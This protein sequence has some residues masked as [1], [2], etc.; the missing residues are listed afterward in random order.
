MEIIDMVTDSKD[1]RPEIQRY[2]FANGYPAQH[3]AEV[4]CKCNSREFKVL[5]DDNQGAAVRICVGCNHQHPIGDSAEYLDNAKLDECSCPCGNE[6]F[7]MMVGVSLYDQSNDVRWIYLGLCCPMCGLIAVYGDWK[8][9]F[10]GYSELL[11][12]V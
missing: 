10:S 3:F 11:A 6:S 1:I 5:I 12:R 4:I 2:S 9:E 8:L 7:E